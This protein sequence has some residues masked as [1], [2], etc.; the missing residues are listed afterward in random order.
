M[1]RT[2]PNL[3]KKTMIYMITSGETEVFY[4]GHTRITSLAKLRAMQK[5]QY[6]LYR[7]GFVPVRDYF[8]VIQHPDAKYR[9]IEERSF[10]SRDE[11]NEY[12]NQLRELHTPP[13][14]AVSPLP[15]IERQRTVVLSL[16][17]F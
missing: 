5:E 8:A 7:D 9:Y 4:I 2:N 13:K 11:A 1:P 17:M 14:L 15:I 10:K 6:A 16:D 3:Y 12:V